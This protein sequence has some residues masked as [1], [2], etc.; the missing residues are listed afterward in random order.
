MQSRARLAVCLC[1]LLTGFIASSVTLAR[2]AYATQSATLARVALPQETPITRVEPSAPPIPAEETTQPML[3]ATPTPP[4]TP[5]SAPSAAPHAPSTVPPSAGASCP[6]GNSV[7]TL[8]QYLGTELKSHEITQ[9]DAI[10]SGDKLV[11]WVHHTFNDAQWFEPDFTAQGERD[12]PNSAVHNVF[13]VGHSGGF[14]ELIQELNA[15]TVAK[16]A[17]DFAITNH[18]QPNQIPSLYDIGSLKKTTLKVLPCFSHAYQ[19]P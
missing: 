1:A 12:A 7:H 2:S 3:A 15:K 8:G 9:I 11:G 4:P 17:N 13:V 5:I 19:G 18:I 6:L 16:V 14:A 10:Y